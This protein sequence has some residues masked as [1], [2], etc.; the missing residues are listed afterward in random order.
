M[1]ICCV[2]ALDGRD[3]LDPGERLGI[4]DQLGR[5]ALAER[6]VLGRGEEERRA[7]AG[8]VEDEG[9][10]GELDPGQIQEIVALAVADSSWRSAAR[11][12]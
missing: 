3:P 9:G 2:R 4:L 8:P 1:A 10:V 7:L 11:R 6:G 12:R 5:D